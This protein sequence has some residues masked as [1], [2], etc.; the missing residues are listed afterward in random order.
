MKGRFTRSKVSP[1]GHKKSIAF[2]YAE[3][4]EGE[5]IVKLENYL[6]ERDDLHYIYII[7]QSNPSRNIITICNRYNHIKLLYSNDP[8]LEIEDIK[9][10]FNGADVKFENRDFQEIKNRSL[11]N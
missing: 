11:E 7:L 4:I 10:Q 9:R 1:K 2:I 6:E 3:N 8:K 5:D